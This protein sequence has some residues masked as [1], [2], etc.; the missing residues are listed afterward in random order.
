MNLAT[1]GL[2]LLVTIVIARFYGPQEYGLYAIALTF[3]ALIMTFSEVGIEQQFIRMASTASDRASAIVAVYFSY[4]LKAILLVVIAMNVVVQLL[5]YSDRIRHVVYLLSVYWFF[6]GLHYPFMT[7]MRVRFRAHISALVQLSSLV[8][9][10]AAL[11]TV[12]WISWPIEAVA[13]AQAVIA[14]LTVGIW[15]VVSRDSVS[16]SG[17]KQADVRELLRGAMQFAPQLMAW[18]LYFNVGT[19]ILSLTQSEAVVGEYSAIFR[20]IFILY[21]IPEAFVHSCSPVLYRSFINDHLHFLRLTRFTCRLMVLVAVAMTYL[22][23]VGGDLV[24]DI[25]YGQAFQSS[26]PILLLLT[27][28]VALRVLS[29]PLLEALT[30]SMNQNSRNVI[31][32]VGLLINAAICVFLSPR[33]GALGAALSVVIAEAVMFVLTLIIVRSRVRL[34]GDQDG[35]F[36]CALVVVVLMLLGA[37][38]FGHD[39]QFQVIALALCA[40]G[41]FAVM[42]LVANRSLLSIS[43][44][45]APEGEQ[46]SA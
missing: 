37:N 36:W 27:P 15:L 13:A 11:I 12:V 28:A 19:F 17:Y 42:Y 16:W 24:I 22:L 21:I 40:F 7:V 8:L 45:M 32:Y 29:L 25:L 9:Q 34:G 2:A 10:I 14:A 44:A 43:P 33:M 3:S 35:R 5:D 6:T 39:Y 1:K 23:T 4:N 38:Q 26:L 30:T 18:A 20:I 41:V 46:T 31:L